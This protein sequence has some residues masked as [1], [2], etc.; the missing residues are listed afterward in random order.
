MT[1]RLLLGLAGAAILAIASAPASAE[2]TFW[3]IDTGTIASP[4]PTPQYPV[5]LQYYYLVTP[6]PCM[7]HHG[8]NFCPPVPRVP[9]TVA[10]MF[11][12]D[13]RVPLARHT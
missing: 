12:S 3:T 2:Q 10:P 11:P 6:R 1:K 4:A 9:P 5:D 8:R 13:R 7:H